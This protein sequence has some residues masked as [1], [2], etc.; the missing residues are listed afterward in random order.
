MMNSFSLRSRFLSVHLGQPGIHIGLRLHVFSCLNMLCTCK[1]NASRLCGIFRTIVHRVICEDDHEDSTNHS[2]SVLVEPMWITDCYR[3]TFIIIHKEPWIFLQKEIDHPIISVP[4]AGTLTGETRFVR[5]IGNY[6]WYVS[7]ARCNDTLVHC[8][9]S[10]TSFE[11]AGYS[12]R[13]LFRIS[14]AVDI[15]HTVH[16]CG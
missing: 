7:Y 9:R 16:P 1:Q 3:C 11:Y 6:T 14:A 4:A 5:C 8:S 15:I 12:T 2:Q 10:L 13:E